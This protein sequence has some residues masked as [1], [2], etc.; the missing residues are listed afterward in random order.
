MNLPEHPTVRRFAAWVQQEHGGNATSAARVLECT[1][2]AVHYLRAGKRLASLT[3]ALAIE[4]ATAGW[5]GGRIS[6]EEWA[7]ARAVVLAA[8]KARRDA[9]KRAREEASAGPM[10]ATG[11]GG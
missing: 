4:Q 1:D 6:A 5:S 11:T 2:T 8:A 10:A 3:L 9:R 7:T